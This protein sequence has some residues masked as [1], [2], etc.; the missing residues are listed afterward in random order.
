MSDDKEL[1]ERMQQLNAQFRASSSRANILHVDPDNPYEIQ[2]YEREQR[3][4]ESERLNLKANILYVHGFASSGNSGT[5]KT[6]QKYLPNCRVVAPD[7]P[8][9]PDKALALLRDIVKNEKID[10]VVGTSMGGMFAQKLRGMPKVLVNPSFHVSESMRRKIGI[11]PF[12]KQRK[13]GATE[14]EVTQALCDA[15]KKIEAGQFDNLSDGEKNITFGLFGT[16]DDVVSCEA[17]FDKYYARKMIFNGGHRLTDK[18]I[19]EYV[20]EAI[21]KLLKQ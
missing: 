14:F 18:V 16:D 5:A 7:L 11:V 10:I 3:E 2:R 1:D 20:V 17:E 19:Y 6:I 9:D 21:L 13:D 8:V 15:Y 12:F 4:F